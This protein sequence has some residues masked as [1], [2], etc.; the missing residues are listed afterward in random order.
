MSRR[1]L[2][3]PEQTHDNILDVAERLFREVGYG[4]TTVADI[5]QALGMSSANVY[6]FFASK[7][8]IHNAIFTR[9]VAGLHA[10]LRDAAGAPGSAADRLAGV[11]HTSHRLHRDLFTDQRRVFDMVEAAMAENWEAIEAHVA[12]VQAII[13][14]V[15][16]DGIAAGEFGP[17]DPDG[18]AA[19]VLDG[20]CAFMHP[21]MIAE[22][23][24][25]PDR[26][27]HLARLLW[28]VIEGLRN[29][30]RTPMP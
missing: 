2:V 6:R 22:C 27:A 30:D 25:K 3:P 15:I 21:T 7:A 17:G 8:D 13:A 16:A 28:L 24:D 11:I 14:G 5:A 12:A 20:S 26:E 23:A 19:A 29:H 9:T 1:A 10:A 18:L 4:K